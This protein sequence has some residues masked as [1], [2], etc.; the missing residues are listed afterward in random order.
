MNHL[1]VPAAT[2]IDLNLSMPPTTKDGY[3]L[4]LAWLRSHTPKFAPVQSFVFSERWPDGVEIVAR[5]TCD[6]S[7]EAPHWNDFDEDEGPMLRIILRSL[8]RPRDF[9]DQMRRICEALHLEDVR[10]IDVFINLYWTQQDW[11]AFF[12]RYRRVEYALVG[13]K[14]A[15]SFFD[16]LTANCD[17]DNASNL[18]STN[19]EPL[20]PSLAYLELR[21][22]DFYGDAGEDKCMWEVIHDALWLRSNIAPLDTLKIQGCRMRAEEADRF[23]DVV[24]HVSWDEEGAGY[25]TS[26][27]FIS[28]SDDDD[29]DL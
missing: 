28:Q 4:V 27:D 21:A 3:G 6:L 12:G 8:Y 16:A 26:D 7:L 19:V 20:F 24:S 17:P 18:P 13:S 11:L 14:C 1:V 9:L 5:D 25:A 10:R 22:M 23:R 15:H 29:D 2:R